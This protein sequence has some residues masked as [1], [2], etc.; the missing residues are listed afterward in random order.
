M[1]KEDKGKQNVRSKSALIERISDESMSNMANERQH[2]NKYISME[3]CKV[4]R[5]IAWFI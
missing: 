1:E 2:M 4:C 3:A 5:S